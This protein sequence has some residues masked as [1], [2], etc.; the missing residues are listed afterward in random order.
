MLDDNNW[1]YLNGVFTR[2]SEAKLPI[3]DLAILRGYG[4]FDFFRTHNKQPFEMQEHFDRFYGSAAGFKLEIPLDQKELNE[5]ILHLLKINDFEGESG[6]KLV[7]TGGTSPSGY[8]PAKPNFFV[9]HQEIAFPDRRHYTEG[10][11]LISKNYMR[12]FAKIKSINYLQ[13]VFLIPEM[14]EAD[15]IDV[16]FHHNGVY[17]E[18][19][20]SNIF[21]VKNG[22]ILTPK[23][24]VLSG[25]SRRTVMK[26]AREHF[27]VVEQD[28]LLS[29]LDQMDEVFISSSIKKVMPVKQIDDFLIDAPGPVTSKVM[30][31]FAQYEEDNYPGL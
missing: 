17:F 21:F 29:E 19:S 3:N 14:E 31:L 1:V 23:D 26:I 11:R 24:D 28:C 30:E 20:R 5:V 12:E 2:L 25:I 18:T 6:F 4:I 13:S 7:L 22:T 27:P 15:A 10:A 9:L 8:K 16:L